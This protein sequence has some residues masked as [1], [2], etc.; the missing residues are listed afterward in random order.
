MT[1]TSYT[2]DS[3][4]SSGET[5]GF[6][7]KARNSVGFSNYSSSIDIIAGT[8]PSTPDA[9]TT[10]SIDADQIQII[11]SSPSDDGGVPISAFIV[12]I[13]ESGGGFS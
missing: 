10:K 11:W 7:V 12:M 8:I 5:Y 6:R 9:P 4:I 3:G 1:E 13:E 2:Q